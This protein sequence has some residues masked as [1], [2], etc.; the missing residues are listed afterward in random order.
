M[1]FFVFKG[2]SIV[3]YSNTLLIK[4][5]PVNRWQFLQACVRDTP[6]KVL[7]QTIF[8]INSMI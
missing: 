1:G 6:F 5:R 3:K 7:H 2:V 4:Q 8:Y